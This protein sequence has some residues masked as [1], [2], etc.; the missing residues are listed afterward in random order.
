MEFSTA[1]KCPWLLSNVTDNM[2]GKQLADGEIK[3]IIEWGDRKVGVAILIYNCNVY[4]TTLY[5]V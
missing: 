3:R 2:S 5:M 4:P 1:T